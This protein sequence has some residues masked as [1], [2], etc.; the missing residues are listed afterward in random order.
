MPDTLESDGSWWWQYTHLVFM[1]IRTRWVFDV[2]DFHIEVLM[3]FVIQGIKILL[4]EEYRG[5]Q[6]FIG[7]S[8]E[9]AHGCLEDKYF[10][11]RATE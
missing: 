7:D 5:S 9:A 4:R 6:P 8:A 3:E 1:A 2:L 11:L 10:R